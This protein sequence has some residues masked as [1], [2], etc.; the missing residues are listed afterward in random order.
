LQQAAERIGRYPW[1]KLAVLI[2]AW[3]KKANCFNN[4][5]HPQ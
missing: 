3:L 2:K 4:L 5:H 1:L